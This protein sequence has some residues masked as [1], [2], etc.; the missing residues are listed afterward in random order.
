MKPIQF[1]EVTNIYE[2]EKVRERRRQEII[3]LKKRRRIQ[4]GKHL[5]FLFENRATVLFQIQEMCRAERIVDDA[6]TREE[7]DV[8]NE[9]VPASRQLSATMMIEI[10]DS[11]EI[12]PVLDSLRGID[13]GEHVWIQVGKEYA[14]PGQFEAG[15]S[16][17]ERGKLSAVHFVRFVFP[18]E[19]IKA[20]RTEDVYLVV[21]HP[22]EKTRTR[23]TDDV[24]ASLVEDLES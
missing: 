19:A 15:R 22:G 6:K 17:E 13:S 5:S 7:I 1:S 11:S 10:E 18:P 21:D 9:L 3:E 24:K 20:L 4:A 8:Y 12:Q 16:D 14:I 2:Y 23:I